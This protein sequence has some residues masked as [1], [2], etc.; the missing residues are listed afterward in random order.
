MPALTTLNNQMQ[1]KQW[2]PDISSLS[3]SHLETPGNKLRTF[4]VGLI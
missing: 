2:L 1:P 3:Q 4:K